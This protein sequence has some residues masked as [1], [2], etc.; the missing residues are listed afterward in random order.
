MRTRGEG[1]NIS[2][3]FAD[4]KSGSPLFKTFSF[5][6]RAAG[7]NEDCATLWEIKIKGVACLRSMRLESWILNLQRNISIFTL[8]TV[9]FRI[10]NFKTMLSNAV[11]GD[12]E[13]IISWW[14]ALPFLNP[15]SRKLRAR[16]TAGAK[17][18]FVQSD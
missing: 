2:K 5:S 6:E 16:L 7:Y 4:I 10:R 1:V 17:Q 13:T 14:S 8:P 18:V 11:K 12:E 15:S 9:V 3:H